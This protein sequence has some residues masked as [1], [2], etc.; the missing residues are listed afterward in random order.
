MKEEIFAEIIKIVS[1]EVEITPKCILSKGKRI[2]VVDARYI[3]VKLLSKNGFYNSMIAE[4]MNLSI[5]SVR[6][7]LNSFD[8]RIDH[9]HQAKFY[10]ERI[11]S[12]YE[13]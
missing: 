6:N 8:E 1:Q 10:Y 2:E 12:I 11:K 13:K 3:I 4:M 9:S 5:R 7:I